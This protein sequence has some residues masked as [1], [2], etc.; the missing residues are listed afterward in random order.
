MATGSDFDT[1]WAAY[2]HKIGKL[3]ARRHYT[4]ARKMTDHD[5]LMAGVAAYIRA[6]PK[7]RP[8][9][10]PATW[11]NQGRWEDQPAGSN[12]PKRTV[13][14]VTDA[15]IIAARELTRRIEA[16]EVTG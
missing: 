1:W 11:L 2:P 6:K 4:A 12:V 16:G 8:W 3:A 10:N 9:C 13:S 15:D 14:T 5:T 7:D